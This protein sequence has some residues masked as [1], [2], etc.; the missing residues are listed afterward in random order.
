MPH[1]QRD[2]TG[3]AQLELAAGVRLLHPEDAVLRGMLSGWA[4]QQLGGRRLDPRTIA[5]RER[6]VNAFV[7]FTNEYPWRWTAA[8]VDEWTSHLVSERRLAKSTIRSYQVALRLFCDYL[9][10]P[11]YG[12]AQEC[13]ERFGTHPIQ[14]CHEWNTAAH[15]VEYEGRPGRRPLTRDEVQRLF[16]YADDRVER[17]VRLGRKGALAAYRDATVLKTIYGWGLRCT[18]VSRLDLAD[19]YRNPQAPALGRFGLV[20]VRY[21]KGTRGSGPRRRM[22]ASLMPWAVEALEDYVV[23]IRP[24]FGMSEHQAVW[25][26]ERGGRLQ[27]REI[28]ERF[29]AYRDALELDKDLSPHCLRHSYV[30]HSIE[31]G[32][33]PKFVQQ[34]VGHLYASTTG[35]Y[36]H[37][38][39]AAMNT[40]MDTALQQAFTTDGQT[41]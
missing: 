18:E 40:M 28:E 3:A 25:V 34:Q 10:S 8:L 33:D 41:Q 12:W 14:V 37:I 20:H 15:L 36:T 2:R 27:P 1:E 29:G 7:A 11:Y 31:D 30:T 5:S 6:T 16:D 22:V 19:F 4:K 23:N 38:S 32:V 26:T 13:V 17:A 24:R 9:I 35:I 39:A 21:G